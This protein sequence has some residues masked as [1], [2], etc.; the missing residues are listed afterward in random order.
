MNFNEICDYNV[1]LILSSDSKILYIVV[2]SQ[3]AL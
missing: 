2:F 3:G 1:N